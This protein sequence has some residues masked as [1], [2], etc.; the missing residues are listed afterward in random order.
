VFIEPLENKSPSL[1][2]QL[3][4]DLGVAVR[5]LNLDEIL[6][7]ESSLDYELQAKCFSAIGAALRNAASSAMLNKFD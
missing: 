1:N 7:S 6:E 3:K 2:A 5:S 4:Q